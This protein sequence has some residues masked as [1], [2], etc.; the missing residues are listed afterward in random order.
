VEA[1]YVVKARVV[2]VVVNDFRGVLAPGSRAGAEEVTCVPPPGSHLY[3]PPPPQEPQEPRQSEDGGEGGAGGE[4][5]GDV[6]AEPRGPEEVT[7]SLSEYLKV[8][9]CGEGAL[10]HWRTTLL[11]DEEVGQPIGGWLQRKGASLGKLAV[12][13]QLEILSA[14]AARGLVK[15]PPPGGTSWRAGEIVAYDAS[16]GEHEITFL[17]GGHGGEG[18]FK[19][20]LFLQ[21]MRWLP[22]KYEPYVGCPEPPAA[23]GGIAYAMPPIPVGCGGMRGVLLPGGKRGEE[24]VRY[25]APRQ[26]SSASASASSFASAADAVA[27]AEFTVP[28]TEFE[29]LGG[30]G[31]AKKW[32]QS[33]R[34]ITLPGFKQGETMGK[35]LRMLGGV[36]AS[37]EGSIGRH[38]E[39]FWP[40]DN[41]FYGGTIAAY[42][43]ETGEH[44][45]YYD[46]GGKEVLQLSM[47]TVRWG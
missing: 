14:A 43:G 3:T 46:D 17:D 22:S 26:T 8:A 38:L 28:A 7:V 23:E 6:A 35:W 18:D 39:I 16:T 12:G 25:A 19:C 32:R 44:E 34:L 30:K 1:M 33:L 5:E 27:M 37:G 11:L 42:K 24:L 45:V 21:T 4:G 31:T 9:G 15:T 13:N 41:A 20:S 2:R 36:A 10:K 40:S 29:R 47:Q